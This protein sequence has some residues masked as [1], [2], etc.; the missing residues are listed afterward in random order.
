MTR[1]VCNMWDGHVVCSMLADRSLTKVTSY[2]DQSCRL[3]PRYPTVTR[4]SPI[5]GSFK[6]SL[7]QFTS[8]PGGC[9][10]QAHSKHVEKVHESCWGWVKQAQIL[11]TQLEAG[12][13][14]V[15]LSS[16]LRDISILLPAPKPCRPE[17]S[18]NVTPC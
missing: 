3:T 17:T 10:F 4:V 12:F 11:G 6:A 13:S 5:S 1:V 9:A 16:S 15:R 8:K 7:L 2:S 14:A 18:E